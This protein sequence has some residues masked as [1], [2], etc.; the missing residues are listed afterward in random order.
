MK[1]K[2]KAVPASRE[3]RMKEFEELYILLANKRAS[4]SF[5]LALQDNAYN[6]MPRLVEPRANR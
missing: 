1:I 5:L 6:A 2:R 4:Q 3:Q